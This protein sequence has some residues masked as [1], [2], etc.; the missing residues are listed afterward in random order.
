MEKY[1]EFLEFLRR[2]KENPKPPCEAFEEAL[3]Y[4]EG[5]GGFHHIDPDKICKE[6]FYYGIAISRN[7][8]YITFIAVNGL[9]ID[10]G[11]SLP[12]SRRVKIE[13]S[14]SY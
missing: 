7:S 11:F 4:I 6:F 3:L 13:I 8:G 5:P 2:L 9:R 12:Y 10:I 14:T 1:E